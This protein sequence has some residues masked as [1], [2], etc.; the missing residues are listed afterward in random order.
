MAIGR[1]NL[2]APSKEEFASIIGDI[3]NIDDVA[4]DTWRVR[5]Q[6]EDDITERVVAASIENG[7]RLKEISLDHTS[8]DVIFAKLSGKL[9]N[10]VQ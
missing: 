6:G 3:E 8:L 2:M 7:W 5:F 9:K 10:N 1:T 4:K